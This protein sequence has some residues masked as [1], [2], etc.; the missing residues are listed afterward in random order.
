[1]SQF[2]VTGG[3]NFVGDEWRKVVR[4]ELTGH[5]AEDVEQVPRKT[6]AVDFGS[7]GQALELVSRITREVKATGYIDTISLQEQ[8]PLGKLVDDFMV[9]NTIIQ[10]ANPGER[11]MMRLTF[12][13]IWMKDCLDPDIDLPE[14]HM[15][16]V[17]F[18]QDVL[19]LVAQL[20]AEARR[21]QNEPDIPGTTT[22]RKVTIPP[23]GTSA[24]T[25]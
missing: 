15:Q 14:H 8:I 7:P 1:V 4:L 17:G 22:V 21:L 23:S 6:L 9:F 25:R 10:F 3:Q 5:Y 20:D 13:G 24:D 16:S 11:P 19:L 18:F 2:R 12:T